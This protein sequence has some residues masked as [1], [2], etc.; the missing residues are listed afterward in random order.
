MLLLI[1]EPGSYYVVVENGSGCQEH[2][3]TGFTNTLN[4]N[5]NPYITYGDFERDQL[6]AGDKVKFWTTNPF[7][8]Y[9]WTGGATTD[10]L[11]LA[12]FPQDEK[13]TVKVN[14]TDEN[15]CSGEDDLRINVF[16]N[17]IPVKPVITFDGAKLTATPS[18][19]N[20]Q[21]YLNDELIAGANDNVYYPFH[22]GIYTV[23]SKSENGICNVFSDDFN[24]E[25]C[26]NKTYCH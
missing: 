25:R 26:W 5:P 12:V 10:T 9:V 7:A 23:E 20:F 19:A 24:F 6:C 3:R 2:D 15:R 18:A 21:W 13:L 11:E 17:A 22:A 8:S 14:V 16:P 4:V 1:T